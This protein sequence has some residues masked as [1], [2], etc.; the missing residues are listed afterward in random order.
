MTGLRSSLPISSSSSSQT[1]PVRISVQLLRIQKK[2][3]A[4][5]QQKRATSVLG[6]GGE[7][8]LLDANLSVCEWVLRMFSRLA[9]FHNGWQA[10]QLDLQRRVDQR[11][12]RS[13]HRDQLETMSVVAP[14]LTEVIDCVGEQLLLSA[15]VYRCEPQNSSSSMRLEEA[16]ATNGTAWMKQWELALDRVLTGTDM[17]SAW[18]VPLSALCVFHDVLDKQLHKGLASL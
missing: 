2:E 14:L 6:D 17:V 13:Q 4:C 18:H 9:E 5:L 8:V 10:K 11:I 15:T 16:R 7:G 3:Y 12:A 1:L